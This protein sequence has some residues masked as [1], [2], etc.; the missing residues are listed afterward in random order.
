[1][2]AAMLKVQTLKENA[3]KLA[4]EQAEREDRERQGQV[5][6]NAAEERREERQAAQEERTQSLAAA[7][8]DLEE[9]AVPDAPPKP[10]IIEYTMRFSGTEQ[11]LL[12]LREYMTANGI[13][14]E[15]LNA[16]YV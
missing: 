15:K 10:V 8:M 1:M 14:Y 9:P 12:K 5:E 2:G 13:V 6:Q 11:Q 16:R 4:R 7:A 3:A